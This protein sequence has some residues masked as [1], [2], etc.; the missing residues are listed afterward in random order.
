MKLLKIQEE[1][2]YRLVHDDGTR[3]HPAIEDKANELAQLLKDAKVLGDSSNVSSVVAMRIASVV[4]GNYELR[5]RRNR[6]TVTPNDE[7][8]Y[9]PLRTNS[10]ANVLP[11][12]Q[13]ED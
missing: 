7:T 1:V 8:S 4:L 3:V 2:V 6:S 12:G 13:P 10:V 9:L 5:G 11:I